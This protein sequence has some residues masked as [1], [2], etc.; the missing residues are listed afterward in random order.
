VSTEHSIATLLARVDELERALRPFALLFAMYGRLPDDRRLLST[1]IGDITAG[2][3]KRARR[4]VA[5]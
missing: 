3:I 2:D 1:A 5:D 4:A